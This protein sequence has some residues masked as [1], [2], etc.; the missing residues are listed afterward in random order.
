MGKTKI[1]ESQ[2]VTTKEQKY[3]K[4]SAK[5]IHPSMWYIY[6]VSAFCGKADAFENR[7]RKLFFDRVWLFKIFRKAISLKLYLRHSL[8]W[9]TIPG[10]ERK[11]GLGPWNLNN[12]LIW[13][14]F[15]NS[16]SISKYTSWEPK[17]DWK[18]L[19]SSPSAAASGLNNAE[20]PPTSSCWWPSMASKVHLII[21]QSCLLQ[22]YSFNKREKL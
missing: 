3:P 21:K 11:I 22:L 15:E 12:Q 5:C 1:C 9:K 20:R 7:R 18:F 10:F 4:H 19:Y 6:Y 17:F 8:N 2:I 14:I 16:I 13:P